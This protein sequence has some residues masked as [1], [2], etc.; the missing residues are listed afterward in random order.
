MKNDVVTSAKTGLKFSID[1]SRVES[2]PFIAL[3]FFSR[4]L[5]FRKNI[6]EFR[7]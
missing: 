7:F 6:A 4:A 5:E 2:F 3:D 1:M